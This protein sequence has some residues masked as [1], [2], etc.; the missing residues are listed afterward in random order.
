[1]FGLS[2]DDVA[3]HRTEVGRLEATVDIE[4]DTQPRELT[5]PDD[6]SAAQ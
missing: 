4:L 5:L 1:M 6:F 2:F 3:L